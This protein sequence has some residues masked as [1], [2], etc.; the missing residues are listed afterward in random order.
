MLASF[1]CRTSGGRQEESV[2]VKCCLHEFINNNEKGKK[3]SMAA[4]CK[5]FGDLDRRTLVKLIEDREG[6]PWSL[7]RD[8]LYKYMMF[9]Q[10]NG[11]SP[12]SIEWHPVWRTFENSKDPIVIIRG[13]G[14]V[15]ASVEVL[16]RDHFRQL[17]SATEA[18]L[19]NGNVENIMI[20]RNCVIVGSPK[21]NPACEIA[22]ARLWGAEPYD[23]RKANRDRIPVHFL[24]IKPEPATRGS[25]ILEESSRYGLN[26]QPPGEKKRRFVRMDWIPQER[27]ESA[28][29][30]GQDAATVVS[31]F[32]PLGTEAE[33]T[34]I[35]I[36]G[37]TGLATLVAAQQATNEKLPEF[38][39]N[40]D[41]GRP[42]FSI[43]KFGYEKHPR[44]GRS[45]YDLRSCEKG[46]EVWGPPWP[47]A[48]G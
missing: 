17:H 12:F 11:F 14:G 22:M 38:D 33:V 36:A 39:P 2:R 19:A 5:E 8:K 7:D 48:F 9:A 46:T 4:L 40:E 37:Y 42:C 21:L 32:R 24:G 45:S 3:W 15:D 47:E 31:C 20:S 10:R 23:S 29:G 1:A 30:K 6:K 34:T 16:L 25:S 41:P 35:I 44:R 18:Q 43:L 26:V 27:F 28:T 13:P